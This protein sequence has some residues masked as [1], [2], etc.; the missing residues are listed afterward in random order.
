[1]S[2]KCF[3]SDLSLGR[4]DDIF[5]S[6][7]HRAEGGVFLTVWRTWLGERKRWQRLPSGL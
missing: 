4:E 6:D 7:V 5:F 3:V 1:M 2:D